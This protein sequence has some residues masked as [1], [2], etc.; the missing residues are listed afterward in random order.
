YQVITNESLT[1]EELLTTT[2][3]VT[4]TPTTATIITNHNRIEDKKPSG[5]MLSLQL[6]T[7]GYLTKNYR[8]KG[9]ATRNNLLPVTVTCHA[10]G[11]KRHYANQCRKTPNNNAHV[12]AY[13]LRDRNAYQDPNTVTGTF[14]NIEMANGN[15]VST[16]TVIQCAT[17]TLLNQHFKIDLMLIKLGSF[18]VV[19]G[20]DWLSKYHARIIVTYDDKVIH[21]PIN[22][23]TYIPINGET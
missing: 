11:E 9:P 18:D 16:N 7:I 10:Y 5:L 23:E 19:I 21:I 14:Y 12:R 3:T 22:G 4:S 15:L 2:T 17:L 13:I 8:N 6:K 20:M 1:T